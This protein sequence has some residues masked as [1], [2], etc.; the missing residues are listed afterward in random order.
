MLRAQAKLIS[1]FFHFKSTFKY[2]NIA[3]L[4]DLSDIKWEHQQF[5]LE[6]QMLKSFL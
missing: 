1:H 2:V 3:A 4:K 5:P 6:G